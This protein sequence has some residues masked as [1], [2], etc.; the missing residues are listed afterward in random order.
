MAKPFLAHRHP[1]DLRRPAGFVE[2]N[3]AYLN[4]DV[5]TAQRWR[6]G[7]GCR[8]PHL[9]D[10]MGRL[11]VS[12]EL[13]TWR[14]S[15]SPAAQ[16][17][18]S[19]SPRP[20]PPPSAALGEIDSQPDGRFVLPRRRGPLWRLAQASGFR[21]R[22]YSGE[23]IADARFQTVTEFDGV[24]QAAAVH[25]TVI[26]CVSVGPGTD[27]MTSGLRGRFWAISQLDRAEVRRNSSILGARPG[28]LA[29]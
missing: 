15:E 25:A 19:M 7:R 9:H 1:W 17:N 23:A 2:G 16:E 14:Q 12:G 13:D 4:R 28:V 26:S 6:S 5:T 8:S 24:E 20:I 10:R 27:G 21:G 22:S 29:R 18:G 3:A 11:R